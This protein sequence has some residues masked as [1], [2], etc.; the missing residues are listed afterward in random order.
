MTL[1]FEGAPPGVQEQFGVYTNSGM[2]FG[3]VYGPGSIWLAGPGVPG[4]PQN[5]T[6]YL[7]IP[8]GGTATLEMSYLGLYGNPYQSIGLFSLISFDAAP[9]GGFTGETIE[10]VSYEERTMRP[11]IVRTNDFILSSPNFQTFRFDSSY[12]NIYVVDVYGGSW[13]MDNL[14]I[15]VVPEPSSAVLLLLGGLLLRM[16]AASRASLSPCA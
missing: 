7:E 9:Y 16:F 14:V 6:G 12:Q 15:G 1:T 3:M 8:D 10:V 2:Y 4:Q 11:P 5:G 13:C